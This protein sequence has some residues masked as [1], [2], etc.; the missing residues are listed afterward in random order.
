MELKGKKRKEVELKERYN[1]IKMEQKIMNIKEIEKSKLKERQIS[2][3]ILL[4][5]KHGQSTWTAHFFAMIIT[6][7]IPNST[8]PCH[9][10]IY[11][12]V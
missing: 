8:K 2:F 10:E 5:K 11:L 9:L 7:F 12:T 1:I 4:N 6:Y 3:I